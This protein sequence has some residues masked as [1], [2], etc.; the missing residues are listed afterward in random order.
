MRKTLFCTVLILSSTQFVNAF[1]AE[2]HYAWTY[3]LALHVG[4]TQR[5]AYQI[6]SAA[7]AIDVD[8]DTGPMEASPGDAVY[9]AR[10][11]GLFALGSSNEKIAQ[12]WKMFHAFAEENHVDVGT[13]VED[14]RR[15]RK[16]DLWQLALKQ[17]NPGPYLH[18]IQDYYSHFEFDNV[19]G[20]AVL[21]HKPDFLSNDPAHKSR[22]MTKDTVDALERFKREYLKQKPNAVDWNRIWQVLD[23]GM[24][25]ANPAPAVG[26]PI[27]F[28][29]GMQEVGAPS[30]A[31]A[32]R[33]VNSA[34][35]EDQ[36]QKRFPT[37]LRMEDP[38][39]PFQWKQFNYDASGS[40]EDSAYSVEKLH[41]KLGPGTVKATKKDKNV[42]EFQLD[43]PYEVTGLV[44]LPELEGLPV[45]ETQQLSDFGITGADTWK[46]SNGTF[47]I[48]KQLQRS[49]KA[50]GQKEIIWSCTVRAAGLE[51][52]TLDT[53]IGLPGN[54]ELEEEQPPKPALDAL[55]ANLTA[56]QQFHDSCEFEKAIDI[57][58]S[59]LESASRFLTES[60]QDPTAAMILKQC[61]ERIALANEMILKMKRIE[62]HIGQSRIYQDSCESGNAILELEQAGKL[63]TATG[64]C[65]E[66]YRAEVNALKAQLQNLKE[67][68][69]WY[70]QLTV[71]AES[72]L[73]ACRF[74]DAQESATNALKS[75]ESSTCVEDF[76]KRLETV[77]SEAQ[78]QLQIEESIDSSITIAELA[79]AKN[80]PDK[81]SAI[82]AEVTEVKDLI[83]DSGRPEC[84]RKYLAAMEI[85]GKAVSGSPIDSLQLD[86]YGQ[87]ESNPLDADEW[88]SATDSAD[89]QQSELVNLTP[90]PSDKLPTETQNT[91]GSG[92]ETLSDTLGKITEAIIDSQVSNMPGQ[93]GTQNS[94]NWNS[95]T[96]SEDITGNWVGTVTLTSHYSPRDS[97]GE[98]I[99]EFTGSRSAERS[100]RIERST[101]G[102]YIVTDDQ[103]EQ[104]RMTGS[105]NRLQF[106]D[107]I[108][109]PDGTVV[110]NTMQLNLQNGMLK[111]TVTMQTSQ[112]CRD[113]L[114]LEATRVR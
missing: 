34:I 80:I 17:G 56:A 77:S 72:K 26:N 71:T 68:I 4:Y 9:G 87:E 99:C 3:Y 50:L 82:L 14:T 18:Y 88:S 89:G 11:P 67:Q 16:Q 59:T 15:A 58:A 100:L 114:S 69:N 84:F 73:K 62:G 27:N 40:V 38:L 35:E 106:S 53:K 28:A 104:K 102:E 31:K 54:A 21:G 52:Q 101:G 63:I 8:P 91:G 112:G 1:E 94:G 51:S 90:P 55:L 95:G 113:T 19:R 36:L 46:R 48:S 64:K 60:P 47:V 24:V 111:G 32:I 25:P 109:T 37:Y 93:S 42:Y 43:L 105:S 96:E 2:G 76:R 97:E 39:L 57:L 33:I 81:K 6:A 74:K 13:V 98:E 108:T 12:I 45:T 103:Q 107:S 20:H 23:E 92:W 85:L 5:Q 66:H 83:A 30:L 49:V 44:D 78:R 29:V 65:A 110:T 7:W 41:L 79:I 75:F 22:S 70:E 61:N 10:H 86:D